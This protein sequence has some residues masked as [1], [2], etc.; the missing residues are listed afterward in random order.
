MTTP[1][2]LAAG[3]AAARLGVKPATL[4]AYVS[5]GRLRAFTL[6]GRRGSWFDPVQLDAISAGAKRPRE[7]RPDLR[8]VSALTLID[9]GGYWYRGQ[10]PADLARTHSFEQ[11]AE[12]LWNGAATGAHP[13]WRADRAGLLTARRVLRS[14]PGD[15]PPVEALRLAVSAQALADP[16]RFDRRP[17][18]LVVTARR[19]MA[20]AL[21]A[22]SGRVGGSVAEQVAVW[23]G[24]R[25]DAARLAAIDD[26]LV[27]MADH[28]LA[29]STVA[30]RVAA[31]FG[32]DPYA[33]VA[34]GF[35]AMSG[36]RH[37]AASR[38]LEEA[39]ASMR[40]RVPPARAAMGL[41][42]DDGTVP[43]FGHPLYP[44]GDPRVPPILALA[45]RLGTT[46]RADRLRESLQLPGAARPNVDFALAAFTHALGV[47]PGAGEA[48]FTAA[49]IAG[50]LAHAMEEYASRTDFRLRAIYSGVR[51]D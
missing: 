20:T 13:P 16:L 10:R 7:R 14:L 32:A 38:R 34:A 24:A 28:E 17:S 3:A 51:P 47:A 27:L 35:G 39:L 33:A 5:R 44:D 1:A 23:I 48:L 4:Y 19:L 21:A 9:R 2:F 49:R 41:L 29:A 25:A 45:A 18:G 11:V 50:W 15:A 42:G 37:G 6:P 40:R 43:G 12:F 31:S 8:I 26:V 46:A 22:T 30:V 36:T